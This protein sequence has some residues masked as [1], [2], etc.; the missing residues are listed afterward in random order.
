MLYNILLLIYDLGD[1]FD[2]AIFQKLVFLYII[3]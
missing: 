3:R 2:I 1:T